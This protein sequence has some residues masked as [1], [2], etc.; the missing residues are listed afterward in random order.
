V[1]SGVELL[2]KNMK[3]K[4]MQKKYQEYPEDAGFE[5]T[6]SFKI[7][8]FLNYSDANW[9][10]CE[11]VF[12][13]DLRVCQDRQ[14][15]WKKIECV[16]VSP[17]VEITKTKRVLEDK[18]S[19]H[20]VTGRDFLGYIIQHLVESATPVL[21]IRE[22]V[23]TSRFIEPDADTDLSVD[24]TYEVGRVTV[25]KSAVGE[26][27]TISISLTSVDANCLETTVD[28]S[29]FT[30]TTTV[31]DLDSV[32][33]LDVTGGDMIDILLGSP[34]GTKRRRIQSISGLR[35]TITEALPAPPVDGNK[36]RQIL[37]NLYLVT[38]DD[39]VISADSYGLFKDSS[40][41]RAVEANIRLIGN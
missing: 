21:G 36:T 34:Y 1:F 7:Q 39:T 23:F 25:S 22:A 13:P 6:V 19:R 27:I 28:D 35:V 9:K 41:T 37:A 15:A 24:D 33:G 31:F 32:A 18:F 40:I 29:V 10:K 11:N 38:P 5:G 30:P 16:Y 20:N 8:G 12:C 4:T 3:N 17:L 26:L 2:L 14:L